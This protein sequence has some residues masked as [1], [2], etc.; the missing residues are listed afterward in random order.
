MFFPF[1]KLGNVYGTL[2]DDIYEN[3]SS[4]RTEFFHANKRST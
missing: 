4:G 2:F 3:E 1:F